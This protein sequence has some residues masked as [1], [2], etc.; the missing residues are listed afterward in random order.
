[1]SDMNGSSYPVAIQ[2]K[3]TKESRLKW[4]QTAKQERISKIV[5]WKQ[6]IEDLLKGKIPEIE[7]QILHASQ[8]LQQLEAHEK[9]VQDSVETEEIK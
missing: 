9:L 6:S 2:S 3:E 7:R 4:I 1:M 5:H 8:E